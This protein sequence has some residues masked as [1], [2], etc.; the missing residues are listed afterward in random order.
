MRA[1]NAVIPALNGTGRC[2]SSRSAAWWT[3]SWASRSRHDHRHLVGRFS[4]L[5]Q[6]ERPVSAEHD[7]LVRRRRQIVCRGLIASRTLLRR[8]QMQT[9]VTTTSTC[10]RTE[11]LHEQQPL[12]QFH[13]PDLLIR[14]DRIT[15]SN[16][17]LAVPSASRRDS[18]SNTIMDVKCARHEGAD[19]RS[20]S[21]RSAYG[22][23][24]HTW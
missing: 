7:L 8:P 10:L 4:A 18:V 5:R 6:L 3:A 23:N 11:C 22:T 1:G 9:L 19:Q 17:I 20:I 12:T 15:I 14:L 21:A 13:R 24:F 2:R 16:L